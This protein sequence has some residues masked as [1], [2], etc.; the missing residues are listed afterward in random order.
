PHFLEALGAWVQDMDGYYRNQGK[1][2]P[3]QLDWKTFSDILMAA[4]M[5]E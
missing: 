5:Y 2:V 4:K 3:E 1:P